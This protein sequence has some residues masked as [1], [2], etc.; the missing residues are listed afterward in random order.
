MSTNTQSSWKEREVGALWKKTSASGS[1]FCSGTITIDVDGRKVTKEVVMYAEKDKKNEKAPD[2]KIYL[3]RDREPGSS[4]SGGSAGKSGATGPAP[5]KPKQASGP[6]GPS[7]SRSAPT[8]QA[9]VDDIPP[10]ME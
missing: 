6:T 10:E 8:R 7:G 5:A 3:S 9:P 1:S 2:F 4:G